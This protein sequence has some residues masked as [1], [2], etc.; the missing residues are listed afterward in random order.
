MRTREC[1][2]CGGEMIHEDGEP[3][4][5]LVGGWQC[6]GCDHTELDDLR[7]YTDELYDV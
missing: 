1:P 4:V 2:K 3:D 6:T 5:G 7:D